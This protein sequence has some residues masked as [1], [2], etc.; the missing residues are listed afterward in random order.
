MRLPLRRRRRGPIALD[1]GGNS[2][3]L[4]QLDAEGNRILAAH[5]AAVPFDQLSG[6]SDYLRWLEDAL[7]RMLSES[8]CTGKRLIGALPS[9]WT[10][11]QQLQLD[12]ADA[13]KAN[14]L[15]A[16]F[17]PP[18]DEEPMTQMLEVGPIPNDVQ[19]RIEFIC[20]AFPRRHVFRLMDLLHRNQYDVLDLRSQIGAS[21]AAFDHIHRRNVDSAIST[22]YIDLGADGVMTAVANGR[23]LV[24]AR[25]IE[26]GSRHF[27]H[28]VAAHLDC[29][30]DAAH[31]Y[32]MAHDEHGG[33]NSDLDA[34]DRRQGRPSTS[35]GSPMAPLGM[36]EDGVVPD[37][38]DLL[39]T[40]IDEL[41]MALRHDAGLFPDRTIDR[42]V[43]LG[44]GARSD[45]TCRHIVEALQL[46]G[47][48]GDPLA[49]FIRPIESTSPVR[50][51]DGPRPGWS[52]AAGLATPTT[53]LQERH[54]AA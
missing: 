15:A 7:P 46:P 26:I 10:T 14:E 3:K 50:R 43:F 21:I 32:R 54:H 13:S 48:R 1:L 35:L 31:A 45:R 42:I 25:R 4:L 44:G 20:F 6:P 51:D 29:D 19:R 40:I 16:M 49:P 18:M 2:I 30:L 52:T 38:P 36:G 28:A 53:L 5:Q 12:A 17:L 9:A 47:Q 24:Q 34:T 37:C 27:D 39:E 33:T 11:V 23:R 41:R 8:G 22:L